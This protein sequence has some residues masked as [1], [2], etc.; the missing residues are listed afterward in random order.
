MSAA[1]DELDGNLGADFVRGS[2][3]AGRVR[4]VLAVENALLNARQRFDHCGVLDEPGNHG[5]REHD[6]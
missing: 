6:W 4:V 5:R 1:S 2:H 3:S